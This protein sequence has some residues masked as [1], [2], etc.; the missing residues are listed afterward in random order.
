M[1][2]RITAFIAYLV[3]ILGPLYALFAHRDKEFPVFHA[4]QSLILTITAIG[5]PLV[6]GVFA[7][8]VFW[9][10]TAG[11]IIAVVA[12]TLVILIYILLAVNWILGL[13]RALRYELKPLPVVGGW[14]ERIPF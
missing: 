9:L 14:A 12:F 5:A 1:S 7:W 3:P 2:N 4:K 13:I 11:P 10:P 6:W 8:V